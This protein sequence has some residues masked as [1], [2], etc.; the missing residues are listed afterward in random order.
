METENAT[1]STELTLEDRLTAFNFTKTTFNAFPRVRKA[2]KQHGASALADLYDF[3]RSKPMLA[4]M[5]RSDAMMG[6][7]RKKQFNHWMN[8]FAGPVGED[9]NSAAHRIGTVHAA[10]GLA[11][12]WYISSYARM[13]EATLPAVI[14]RS[15]TDPFGNRSK[16][17]NALIKASLLDMDIA[18]SAYFDVEEAKRRKVIDGVSKALDHL[19]SGNFSQRMADLPEGYEALSRDFEA[20]RMRVCETLAQVKHTA[21]EIQAESTD[22]SVAADDLSQR[23]AQQAANLEQSAAAMAEITQAVQD[24]AVDTSKA[25][26]AVS[27]ARDEAVSG[28]AVVSEAVTAMDA[29]ERSS[30][31][32]TEII[33]MIDGIAFQTNILALNAG[34]E[35]ARAGDAGRGF[36]IVAAEVRS[37]AQRTAEAANEVKKRVNASSE[38][39]GVGVELVKSS[40]D[41]LERIIS[42]VAEASSAIRT[43]AESAQQQA[44][45]LQQVNIGL[46]EMDQVTQQNAAMVE[47]T[48]AGARSLAEEATDLADMMA[49]FQFEIGGSQDIR[50]IEEL[51]A[52]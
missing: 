31:E 41:S 27:L 3:I 34:V 11:P 39:I 42:S 35:A 23:T 14:G 37:L 15:V 32:I 21:T 18:L 5:F 46:S 47:Q 44:R 51:R 45:A 24:S 7:A 20:M 9:Y 48:T 38:Q 4:K 16:A 26:E 8:L 52:A 13:L 2:I 43:I 28:G 30:A 36:G 22:I 50:P 6:E 12:T 25:D 40:G 33:T 19:A 29:I 1:A 10:I 49:G 17:A